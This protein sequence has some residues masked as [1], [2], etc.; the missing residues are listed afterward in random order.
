VTTG[1]NE[2]VNSVNNCIDSDSKPQK[3]KAD[4]W[5]TLGKAGKEPL[6]RVPPRAAKCASKKASFFRY[7]LD[8]QIGCFLGTTCRLFVSS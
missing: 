5:P 2:R 4:A 1:S 3:N 6:Q 8:P 7:E